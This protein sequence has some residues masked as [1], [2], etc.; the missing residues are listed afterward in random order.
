MYKVVEIDFF[1]GVEFQW[2]SVERTAFLSEVNSMPCILTP[3]RPEPRCQIWE[4]SPVQGKSAINL[5]YENHVVKLNQYFFIGQNLVKTDVIS[6]F[7]LFQGIVP[8]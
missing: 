3:F 7:Y 1:S 4:F 8:I 6:S 2:Q 5:I